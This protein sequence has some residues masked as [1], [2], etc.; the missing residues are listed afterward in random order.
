MYLNI[1]LNTRSRDLHSGTK[2]HAIG[3]RPGARTPRR[4]LHPRILHL[5]SSRA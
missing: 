3:R 4:S 2:H 1:K 5:L